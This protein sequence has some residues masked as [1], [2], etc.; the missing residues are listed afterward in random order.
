[1]LFAKPSRSLLSS[2]LEPRV[3][4]DAAGA[5]T[6]EVES[7][8]IEYVD[9]TNDYDSNNNAYA[10]AAAED[11][12][13]SEDGKFVYAVSSN[14]SAWGE[15]SSVLSVF[16]V[17]DDGSL[18]LVKTYYNYTS[19]YNAETRSNDLTIENEGL[20]GATLISMSSDQNYL[21]VFGEGDN[22]LVVF[23]R[24]AETGELTHLGS[25][26]ISGFGIDGI[27]DFVSDIQASNGYLYVSGGDQVLVLSKEED[28]TLSLVA[29][30]SNE[31]DGVSGLSGTNSIAISADGTTLIVG[32]SG[33]SSIVTQ[34]SVADDGTLS[35][36][37]SVAGE[38]ELYFINSV[39]ISADG[40][41]VYALNNNDGSSLLV[42]TYNDVGEL[43]LS[44][45]YSVSDEA[46]TILVSEDGTGVFVMG[47]DIDVFLQD[48]N[49][50]LTLV[51]TIDAF[52][53]DLGV[54]FS[55]I[56]HAYLS[57]DHT[58]L[59][60]VVDNGILSFRF[61]VPA[62]S[63]TEN[64]SGTLLLPTGL[65]S[66]SE[67]DALE[68]YEGASY[69]VARESETSEE[70]ETGALEE[71][72][73]GFQE[74]NGLTLEN[75]KIL[76]DG[77]EIAT[78]SVVDDVLT[79][80]FVAPTTQ[81]IAQQVL[82]QITYSNTS[83]DPLA[84]GENPSFSIRVNDGDG[85][86][87]AISVTVNLVG[88]NNPAVITTTTN[89]ITFPVGG[90]YTNLFHDTSIETT[91]LDQAIWQV[92]LSITDATED[93]VIKVGN[94]K[95]S[96]AAFSGT[97]S[98]VDGTSYAVSEENGVVTVTLYLM[99]SAE[100]AA[101]VIDSI[102][103]KYFGDEVSGERTVSLSV[104]EYTS[105]SD[106]GENTTHYT[107]TT[108]ITLAA[109]AETN[110][111]P[112]IDSQ[113]NQVAY[114]ENELGTGIFPNAVVTDSQMDAYNEGAGNYHGAQLTVSFSAV[115][116]ND[117]FSFEA[118]N[119]L[120]LNGSS[121][122]KDGVEIATVSNIDG[123]LTINFTEDNG[124]IPTTEDVQNVLN[125][126]QYNNSS[127]TPVPLVNVSVTLSDQFG[128]TSNVFMTQIIITAVNDAPEVSKDPFIAA[129]DMS[130]VEVFHLA[131]GLDDVSASSVSRDGNVFYLADSSGNIAV[132]TLSDDAQ[133][134][135][136]QTTLASVD[137]VNSVDKMITSADGK[138]LYLLANDGDM[139]SVY[140]LSEDKVLSNLQV[141]V[142]D[143]DTNGGKV[144]GIQDMVLSEDGDHLYFI[145]STDLSE[146]RLNAATGELTYEQSIG[147]AWNE[148]YLWQPTGLS[149]SGDYVFVTTKFSTP[150]LIVFEQEESGL[151]WKAYI[152]NG[153]EDSAGNNAVLNSIT[154]VAATDD[155]QYVYVVN[156]T[157]I[158]TYSY[159][160]DSQSFDVINNDVV[161]V[162]NLSDV[163]VSADSGKLFVLA[164]DGS[165]HRYIIGENGALSLFGVMTGA[166][167]E[168][169]YLSVSD[170]GYVFLQGDSLAIYDATGRE[171][172]LYEIG[173]EAVVLEPELTIFD[174]EMSVL[175]NYSGL[176]LSLSR[177][178]LD[179]TD[180]FGLATDSGFSQ[181]GSN[182]LYQGEVVGQFVSEGGAL[183]ISVTSELTQDQV[184]A[185]ARSI[186]FE[187]AT[188]TS[189][190]A[191]TFTLS[192][193]DGGASGE[194]IE[195]VLNSA[196][197]LPPQVS[198][199][200]QLPNI[201]ETEQ[202]NIHLPRDLFSDAIEDVLTWQI[203]GLPTGLQFH[204]DSL[205][206][207]GRA[208]ESGSFT[209]VLQVTDS[210]G[211]SAQLEMGWLVNSLPETVNIEGSQDD[212]AEAID[213]NT[214]AA[215]QFFA[216]ASQTRSADVSDSA[217]LSNPNGFT[218]ALSSVERS[219]QSN[220]PSTQPEPSVSLQASRSTSI[221]WQE[222][223]NSIQISLLDSVM[224]VEEK[225][226]LAVMS[227]DG[228]SL[229]EGVEYDIETGRLSLDRS[230]LGDIDQLQLRVMAVDENGETIVIPV[231]ITLDATND[232]QV[233]AESFSERVNEASAL[234][235]LEINKLLLRDLTT[236][237]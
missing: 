83:N 5:A 226:I 206:I 33:E 17:E 156:D 111:A 158:Y 152:R 180:Q 213:D 53:N 10:L 95:I 189:V 208:T 216:N 150:T 154:H 188:L 9:K 87:T 233:N 121:L 80:T 182:L 28:G 214:V 174:E 75:G 15:A 34:F 110:I 181:D 204:S 237:S 160:A 198:G 193:N 197:N 183:S 114:T 186:T 29:Q 27:S 126:I 77:S 168:G 68:D 1:M 147:S 89:E 202:V 164:S 20:A 199:S 148:P 70:G 60:V 173:F 88:I 175:D 205:S 57:A 161:S 109:A 52:S 209:L 71:D 93:D 145:T 218:P 177:S 187:N 228:I 26:E 115:T 18:T 102:G 81:L 90:D 176:N 113:S 212:V 82:R 13:V 192:I 108:N 19:T 112:V 36:V 8:S 14:S 100:N 127:E 191:L 23:G 123:V 76:K 143:Y 105:V 232:A 190:G 73:Y 144:S 24:N 116:S 135:E 22:S 163:V 12:S 86:E 104:V 66:D 55:S 51:Q 99:D 61:D 203:S 130:L 219:F 122:T 172:S 157:S 117:H 132:F 64:E 131:E 63:Y 165:L 25:T 16:G 56:S 234:S 179:V 136:Y 35:Y 7:T 167:S 220:F 133:E 200:Y 119:G 222:G 184:N 118:A 45:T 225:A 92:K 94:G 124:A 50:E 58:T 201:M 210:K 139:I 69:T 215:M 120:S 85:N 125:Q 47:E 46:R 39:Q 48:D 62:V 224:S 196:E 142:S 138:S 166:S 32:S 230:L 37:N 137:G 217:L 207:V 155:G 221:V 21:Y 129:G 195:I 74:N 141:I 236:A 223:I 91:E 107:D 101:D 41:T 2:V 140:A 194:P 49:S 185:L 227:A 40:Q 79:V 229:P 103:Y 128:L 153:S 72:E 170:E 65:I 78:F 169:E 59:F 67:L 149:V 96:L 6:L 30:Y 84:N 4:F 171:A 231:E 44:S 11:V 235:V 178:T 54:R 106:V 146:M 134:W 159:D 43:T 151:A 31:T 211:Q 98:T 97:L 3:M 162:E 42:M 38:D